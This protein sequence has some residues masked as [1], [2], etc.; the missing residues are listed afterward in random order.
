MQTEN[1]H[2]GS[3][4]PLSHPTSAEWMGFLY[5]ETASARRREMEQ[6]LANC[7]D[8]TRQLKVWR[9]TQ[10]ELNEW[11]MPAPR[12]VRQLSFPVLRWA[13][14]AALILGLGIVI[15]HAFSPSRREV[16][17]L[18]ASVAQLSEAVQREG[19]SDVSGT[20]AAAR[21]AANTE[22]LRLLTQY[23]ALQDN[24][25]TADQLAVKDVLDALDVRIATLRGELETVAVNTEGSFQQTRQ[26]LAQLTSYPA[27]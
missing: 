5:K 2:A 20:V 1:Q 11:A 6:H 17:A 27:Q 25:R 7:P 4:D 13:T 16:A 10:S 23:R 12:R 22:T 21:A 3:V 9:G 19:G 15:G 26:N 8:C 14:A 18:K 24:Q